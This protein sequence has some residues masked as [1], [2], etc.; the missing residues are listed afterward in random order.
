MIIYHP[1]CQRRARLLSY[2][3]RQHNIITWF[4]VTLLVVGIVWFGIVEFASLPAVLVLI[5]VV[6]CAPFAVV[7]M[8]TW[9]YYL[10]RNPA[11]RALKRLQHVV[12]PQD[13]LE[14]Y[15][16][17]AKTLGVYGRVDARTY[18]QLFAELTLLWDLYTNKATFLEDRAR[19]WVAIENRM[20]EILTSYADANAATKESERFL[21]EAEAAVKF[22]AHQAT[23]EAMLR[24]YRV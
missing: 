22:G 13:L 16:H 5:S 17:T 2:L 23:V 11:R 1:S 4:H 7:T 24:H 19:L 12:V 20:T 3:T 18:Y 10:F 8:E 9:L 21:A 14:Y 6:L 15:T